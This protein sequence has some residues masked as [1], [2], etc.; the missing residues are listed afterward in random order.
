MFL[1]RAG[2][3]SPVGA[4]MEDS[5]PEDPYRLVGVL[6]RESVPD[7]CLY[8][9]EA[10][11]VWEVVFGLVVED[12]VCV[13]AVFF[14]PGLHLL[15]FGAPR[16]VGRLS[17]GVLSD[18][19]W[20]ETQGLLQRVFFPGGADDY[21]STAAA[22]DACELSDGLSAKAE[23][24]R[25]GCEDSVDVEENDVFH[26]IFFNQKGKSACSVLL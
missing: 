5:V 25:P 20:K 9:V 12:H 14:E 8:E 22:D 7:V 4:G 24:R 18:R 1:P 26:A 3:S 17:D 6:R 13:G 21:L 2:V 10:D 19:F 11:L 15:P 16:Q 23:V